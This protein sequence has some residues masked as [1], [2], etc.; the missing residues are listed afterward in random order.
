MDFKVPVR[1]YH[2]RNVILDRHMPSA[3]SVFGPELEVEDWSSKHA[4]I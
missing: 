3:C 2:V 4:R 1:A